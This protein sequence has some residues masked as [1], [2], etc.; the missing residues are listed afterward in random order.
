MHRRA[1]SCAAGRA[2]GAGPARRRFAAASM[3]AAASLLPGAVGAAAA[4]A[5][6][7]VEL[8]EFD[9]LVFAVPARAR[10]AFEDAHRVRVRA[11]KDVADR[12]QFRADGRT[13]HVE[14]G[15]GF[16][17]KAPIDMALACRR[18]TS[19]R[20][21]SAGEIRLDGLQVA[22]FDIAVRDAATL[23]AGGL[24]LGTLT[25]DV[26]DGGSVVLSGRAASQQVTMAGAARYDA[27]NLQTER[28]RV[29]AGGASDAV[30]R[31][32]DDLAVRVGDAAT[33]RYHGSPRLTES[34]SGAGTL[35]KG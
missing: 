30:L 15:R 1:R 4:K 23:V 26:A 12:L 14:A 8:A 20:V 13:L 27:L 31:V 7:T 6:R 22:S 2:A 9:R 19:L 3:A 21:L 29:Q 25:V 17:A 10:I 5:E 16:V 34:V 24:G 35:R 18:L 33:V 28:A 11:E 32:R